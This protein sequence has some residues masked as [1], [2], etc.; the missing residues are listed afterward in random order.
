MLE[1]PSDHQRMGYCYR[2]RQQ[3]NK[4]QEPSFWKKE[5]AQYKQ[6]KHNF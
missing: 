5:E 4:Q 1:F 6:S 2:R 3:A